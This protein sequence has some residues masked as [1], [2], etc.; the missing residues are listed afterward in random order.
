[1][2]RNDK[3]ADHE[4]RLD[5]LLADYIEACEVGKVARGEDFLARHPEFSDELR[6]FIDLQTVVE[7][8]AGPL[9]E[10]IQSPLSMR[11]RIFG[12]RK[13]L[14]RIQAGNTVVVPDQLG[15]WASSD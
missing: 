1:M 7:R 5:Q 9:R 10:A 13:T 6:E 8:V 2:M 15:S 3:T 11:R 4:S 14:N 12:I